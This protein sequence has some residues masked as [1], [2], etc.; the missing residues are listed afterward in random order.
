MTRTISSRLP[1]LVAVLSSCMLG[2]L[3]AAPILH[4]PKIFDELRAFADIPRLQI[5][6]D[7]FP[8]AL[9]A[10]GVRRATIRD[11]VEA[12]LKKGNIQVTD[13]TSAPKLHLKSVTMSDERYPDA[14]GFILII[15]LVQMTRIVRLDEKLFLATATIPMYAIKPKAELARAFRDAVD[16]G[17]I[18]VTAAIRMASDNRATRHGGKSAK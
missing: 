9:A 13:D 6:V 14:V 12:A 16:E 4:R 8:E 1:L 10:V 7:P 3:V 15:D 17:L 11:R 18:R 5:E 2:S